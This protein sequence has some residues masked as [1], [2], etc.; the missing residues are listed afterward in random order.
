[1]EIKYSSIKLYQR[2]VIKEI[3]KFYKPLPTDQL[4]NTKRKA[5]IS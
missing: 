1:M 2:K 5:K 4:N 3:N